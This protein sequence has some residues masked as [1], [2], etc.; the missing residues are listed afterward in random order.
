LKF[1]NFSGLWFFRL[2]IYN[3][4]IHRFYLTVNFGFQIS[5]FGLVVS[6]LLYPFIKQIE[7]LKSKIRIPK[8]KIYPK[9]IIDKITYRKR[10]EFM[11]IAILIL[12]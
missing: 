10:N 4:D 7:Y 3:T 1:K 6:L 5:D 11:A 9:L 2:T 12:S 8:S